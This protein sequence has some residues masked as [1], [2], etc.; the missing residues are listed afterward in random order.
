MYPE[1]GVAAVEAVE[2]LGRARVLLGSPMA[3]SQ[4]LVAPTMDRTL[5]GDCFQRSLVTDLGRMQVPM[6]V[7]HGEPHS[8]ALGPGSP[9]PS[10]R[11][12]VDMAVAV[13]VQW[14]S[15]RR[16]Q[17][18]ATK[19]AVEVAGVGRGRRQVALQRSQRRYQVEL[20]PQAVEVKV[21]GVGRGRRQVELGPQAG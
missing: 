15:E 4:R 19:S 16:P 1:G 10:K 14:R 6:A 21:A 2:A 18:A 7:S 13:V 20:G 9:S 8:G 5:P 11:P 17:V 3:R 12:V